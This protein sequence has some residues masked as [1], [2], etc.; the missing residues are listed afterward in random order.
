MVNMKAISRRKKQ[1][2]PKVCMAFGKQQVEFFRR[3]ILPNAIFNSGFLHSQL[4]TAAHRSVKL[5]TYHEIKACKFIFLHSVLILLYVTRKQ[6]AIIA[7]SAS[8]VCAACCCL[9]K[10]PL[11]MVALPVYGDSV[12]VS[13]GLVLMVILP[14]PPMCLCSYEVYIICAL[15]HVQFHHI[16]Q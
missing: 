1:R 12:V 13:C 5:Y 14:F 7:S 4:Q 10:C 2:T 11:V 16:T 15:N 8:A 6:S 9:V 3:K